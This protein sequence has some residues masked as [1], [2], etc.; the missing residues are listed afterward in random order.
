MRSCRTIRLCVDSWNYNTTRYGQ[1]AE[2]RSLVCCVFVCGM[3][4]SAGVF[5]SLTDSIECGELTNWDDYALNILAAPHRP[6]ACIDAD[7][8]NPLCQLEGAYTL[9]LNEFAT[10]TPYANMAQQC[11]SQAP[12]YE[13][14]ADC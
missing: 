6:A 7:P 10:K 13:K 1:V 8:N 4:K 12:F 9:Q 11:P 3:W 14:P 5:G 2:G